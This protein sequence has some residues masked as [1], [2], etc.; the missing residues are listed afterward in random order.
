MIK[1]I[2]VLFLL[3]LYSAAICDDLEKKKDILQINDS[4]VIAYKQASFGTKLYRYSSYLLIPA[5]ILNFIQ[6]SIR[7]ENGV[8]TVPVCLFLSDIA[9]TGMVIGSEKSMKSAKFISKDTNSLFSSW[10][11]HGIGLGLQIPV[12]I[13]IFGNADGTAL[14]STKLE[15]SAGWMI[16]SIAFELGTW[17]FTYKRNNVASQILIDRKISVKNGISIDE[18]SLCYK[19]QLLFQF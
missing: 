7:N 8:F 16:G 15:N 11:L 6:N 1:T 19:T 13:E 3:I 10:Y 17:Y 5:Y 14:Q 4:V 12:W 18:N 2:P 9:T